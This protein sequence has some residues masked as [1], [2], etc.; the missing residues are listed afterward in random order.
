MARNIVSSIDDRLIKDGTIEVHY[1]TPGENSRYII[2][3]VIKDYEI[4]ADKILVDHTATLESYNIRRG[5]FDAVINVN[6]PEIIL[7][8]NF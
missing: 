5:E 2:G 4:E 1:F 7:L 6:D 3:G 8:C